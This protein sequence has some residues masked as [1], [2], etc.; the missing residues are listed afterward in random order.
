MRKG[1]LLAPSDLQQGC[2]EQSKKSACFRKANEPNRKHKFSQKSF[3]LHWR[4]HSEILSAFFQSIWSWFLFSWQVPAHLPPQR[5]PSPNSRFNHMSQWQACAFSPLK[6]VSKNPSEICGFFWLTLLVFTVTFYIFGSE[7]EADDPAR[8][9][10]LIIHL[11]P[12]FFKPIHWP[13]LKETATLL[14]LNTRLGRE[15]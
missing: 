10:R 7:L 6:K 13:Y 2:W 8:E 15:L 4:I 12:L 1:R 5:H 9:K 14:W 11:F 3:I